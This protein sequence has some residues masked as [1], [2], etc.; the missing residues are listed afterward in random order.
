MKMQQTQTCTIPLYPG[1]ILTPAPVAVLLLSNLSPITCIACALGPMK[2]TPRF[3]SSFAN[4]LFSDK[5]PY[6]G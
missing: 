6:P 1:I 4:S 2:T 3:A 5:N